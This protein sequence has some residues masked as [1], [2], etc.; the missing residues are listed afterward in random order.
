M[1]YARGAEFGTF[2]GPGGKEQAYLRVV[3][4]PIPLHFLVDVIVYLRKLKVI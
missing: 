1:R 4:G 3:K 2:Y